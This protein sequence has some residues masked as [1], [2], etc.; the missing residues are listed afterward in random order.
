MT[1]TLTRRD[2]Q[3]LIWDSASLKFLKRS[4]IEMIDEALSTLSDFG[5][6]HLIVQ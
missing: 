5:E 4:Q 1:D 3:D 2:E 6:V